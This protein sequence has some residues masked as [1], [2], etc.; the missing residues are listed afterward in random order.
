MKALKL[1]ALGIILFVSSTIQAQ[2]SVN[3]NIGSQPDWGPVGYSDVNFYYLPDVEAYY[4]IGA[5]QFIYINNGGWIRSRYLPGRYRNYDLYHG[6]K[7]VLNDYHGSTPYRNFNS[8][9]VIYYKGYHGK[10]Q[11]NIGRR[12]DNQNYNDNFDRDEN[13][14]YQRSRE[15]DDRNEEHEH[16]NGH[17]HGHGKH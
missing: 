3:I 13:N 8:H 6:Y 4:D 9:K 14:R 1:I 15:D 10:P 16:G 5:A 7:V 17:G 12:Y 2:I 11:K